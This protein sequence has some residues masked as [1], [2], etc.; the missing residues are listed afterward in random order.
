MTLLERVRVA[1]AQQFSIPLSL[2]SPKIILVSSMAA[3]TTTGGDH[4]LATEGDLLVR[5]VSS[6]QIHATIP[7]TTLAAINVAAGLRGSVVADL[8]GGSG[9]E[10]DV[11]TVRAAHAAGVASSSARF[12]VD[13]DSGKRRAE[14]V[15]LM[16]T[17]REIMRGE[18][19]IPRR[20]LE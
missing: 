9:G 19:L 16:R 15:V 7:G 12:I 5:S 2:A 10:E 6:G 1:A 18:V 17:A 8:I 20:V 14:S 4:V 3:Y 11:V 13:A